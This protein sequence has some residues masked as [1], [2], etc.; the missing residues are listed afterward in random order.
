MK[1]IVLMVLWLCA[2]LGG[3][4]A[5]EP[6]PGSPGE[7]DRVL[8]ELVPQCG[9]AGTRSGHNPGS[10][11]PEPDDVIWDGVILEFNG[12]GNLLE[13]LTFEGSQ[14]PPIEVRKNQEMQ[15]Y[16]V[17]N[18]TVDLSGV[19]TLQEFLSSKSDYASNT[20]QRLE[21]T[22]HFGGVFT[23]DAQVT[24]QMERL[25]SKIQID[26]ML[27][28]VHNSEI[29]TSVGFERGYMEK[30]P[31]ACGYDLSLPGNYV[32]AYMRGIAVG[33]TSSYSG[34]VTKYTQGEYNLWEYDTPWAVYCYPN[35][36]QNQDERNRLAVWYRMRYT[37]TGIDSETGE[38]VVMQRYDDAC[39][40]LVLPPLRPNTV[41]ELENLILN[42]WK[43][44]T[45]YLKSGE[46]PLKCVFR[47]T[48]MTSGEYLGKVEGEVC[49]D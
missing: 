8:L 48:D 10:D 42:G 43:S 26:G 36:S 38:T 14:P 11:P 32:N 22:G 29:Y 39:I 30:A 2:L 46:E 47:M 35:A 23:A 18:P 12:D 41:Y 44:S 17:A 45:V 3:C 25:L 37:V 49:H 27:F 6:L 13:M 33:C 9:P 15:I 24:V 40:R 34:H 19:S 28:R 1:R 21:M 31:P 20:R 5:L 4:D 16:V 7:G